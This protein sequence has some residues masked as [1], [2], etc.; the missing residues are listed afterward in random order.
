MTNTRRG[1]RVAFVARTFA[2]AVCSI[3]PAHSQDVSKPTQAAAANLAGLHDFD[4]LVGEWRVHHRVKRPADGP[5][6]L[7]FEGT[8]SNRGL[9]DGGA[10][11]E[12]HVFDKPAGVSRGVAMRAYDPGTGQW[13]IWW[14]DGRI[15]HG[16][17]D[18]P[19]RGGFENGVGTFYSDGTLDGKPIRT[20]F[21][22]SQITPT[23]AR[24][25]QAY[26]SDAGKTWETNWIME[27]RRAS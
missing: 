20:R 18:P 27:F 4:F 13:A 8:C 9:M 2:V 23:S 11:V 6:W 10:N 26:S 19:V 25:E 24:W 5:H 14:I 3:G 16:A 22:W 12:E 17:L 21:I 1:L 15:P 7:E